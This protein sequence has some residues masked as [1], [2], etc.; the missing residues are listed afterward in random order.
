[1]LMISAAPMDRL[2]SEI[3]DVAGGQRRRAGMSLA[4]RRSVPVVQK[5]ILTIATSATRSICRAAEVPPHTP[6]NS[7][8][9][10]HFAMRGGGG[11]PSSESVTLNITSLP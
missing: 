6:S 2:L 4:V 10:F 8:P 9:E 3:R 11:V 1:M 7:S 5:M